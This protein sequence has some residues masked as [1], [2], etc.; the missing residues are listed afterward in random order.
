MT[1]EKIYALSLLQRIRDYRFKLTY[2]DS[3]GDVY[4]RTLQTYYLL[5]PKLVGRE[6]SEI[7]EVEDRVNYHRYEPSKQ[8]KPF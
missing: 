6:R 5:R 2:D 4:R 8:G 3:Y 7:I 1:L